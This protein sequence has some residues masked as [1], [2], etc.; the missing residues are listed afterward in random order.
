MA[1]GET[2]TISQARYEEL[3]DD[4]TRINV[5]CYM[6]ARKD[7]EIEDIFSILLGESHLIEKYKSRYDK[8][9]AEREEMLTKYRDSMESEEE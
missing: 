3:L 9:K 7:L 6:L 5:L 1:L 4:E 2:V 8:E